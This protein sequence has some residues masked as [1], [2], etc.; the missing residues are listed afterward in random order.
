MKRIAICMMIVFFPVFLFADVLILKDGHEIKTNYYWKEDRNRI[1]YFHDGT[2]KYIERGLID[3]ETMKNRR[4]PAS[5]PTKSTKKVKKSKESHNGAPHHAKY[6]GNGD[7]VISLTKPKKDGAA[8][9]LVYGN[10]SNRHFSITGYSSSGERTGLLVNSVK[11]YDGTVLIDMVGKE[12]T[13]QLEIKARGAWAI[14]VYDI[15]YA[16]KYKSPGAIEGAGDDVIIVLGSPK[17]MEV[18]GNPNGRHFSIK[19]Y[20]KRGPHL[21]V[22]TGKPYSGKVRV[23][24]NTLLLEISARGRWRLDAK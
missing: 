8:M 10:R 19:G 24:I 18:N 1:G 12:K 3:W 4:V 23:P 5:E 13:S 9:L 21:L 20:S 22:N 17:I 16:R 11:K 14:Y 2:T 7:D 15:K 6:T